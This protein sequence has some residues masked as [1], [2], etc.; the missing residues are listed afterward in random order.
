[1][2]YKKSSNSKSGKMNGNECSYVKSSHTASGSLSKKMG[3]KRSS[4]IPNAPLA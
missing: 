4:K 3:N 1:M 2:E